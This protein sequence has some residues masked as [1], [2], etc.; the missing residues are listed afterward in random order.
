M[1]SMK[2]FFPYLIK[3]SVEID[4]KP[5]IDPKDVH[6]CIQEYEILILRSKMVITKELL[7]KATK[8]KL[9]GR[10]GA[11]LDNIDVTFAQEQGIK[12]FGANAGNMDAVAEHTIGLI[13]ALLNNIVK[14][15]LEIKDFIWDREGNRGEELSEKTV[16]IIGYG[17]MGKAVAK[18]LKA[19]G[20]R[21]LAY[22]KYLEGYSDDY[23]KEV[24]MNEIFEKVDILTLHVPLTEETKFLI[25]A[26]YIEKF[27]KP[28]RIINASRGKIV[29]L[30]DL[31][32]KLKENKIVG[33]ALDVLENENFETLQ[34][35]E[36]KNLKELNSFD[37]VILTP[38]IAGWSVDSY[39]KISTVLGQQ[40]EGELNL[41]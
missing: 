39:R 16:G 29:L 33:A 32:L 21:I 7:L 30:S 25:K 6:L 5:E 26:K 41:I 22:D 11:G 24:S 19:F 27:K 14:S 3:C 15:N 18:R 13:L 20:C 1:M 34:K 4:Y 8:L 31:I 2:V 17:F 36:K 38:H 37:N 40:L 12:V 23:V 28:I 35:V 10:A 9:I